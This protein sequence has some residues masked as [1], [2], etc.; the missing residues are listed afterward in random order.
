VKA[1][2]QLTIPPANY[3]HTAI[4]MCTTF[5]YSLPCGHTRTSCIARCLAGQ[6]YG[7][8]AGCPYVAAER[9]E[10]VRENDK[11]GRCEGCLVTTAQAGGEGQVV[12]ADSSGDG[13]SERGCGDK[14]VKHRLGILLAGR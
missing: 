7:P 5:Y 14:G 2:T 13:G 6:L 1:I 9:L 3:S 4:N 8:K 12:D 11:E 10:E